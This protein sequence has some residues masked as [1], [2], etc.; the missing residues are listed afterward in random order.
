MFFFLNVSKLTLF[1]LHSSNSSSLSSVDFA[2]LF[3]VDSWLDT[4]GLTNPLSSFNISP[5]HFCNWSKSPFPTIFKSG[6]S[7]LLFDGTFITCNATR[8]SFRM[9]K[10][11][12]SLTWIYKVTEQMIVR[13]ECERNEYKANVGIG[14]TRLSF[15]N[16]YMKLCSSNNRYRWVT[17]W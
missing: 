12:T 5:R 7:V 14:H 10:S 6:C 11:L 15:C 9:R 16:R 2:F 4:S 8:N 17:T 1:F 3:S 13:W